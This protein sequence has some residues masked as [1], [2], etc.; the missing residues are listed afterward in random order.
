MKDLKLEPGP[1]IGAI[2][3]V[4]LAKVIENPALNDKKELL[5]LVKELIKN[6]L[7]QLRLMAKEKILEEQEEEDKR[8]KGK[9]WVK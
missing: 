6:D 3:D 2:L 8:I 5:M 7:D 9:Y 1:K 4:L